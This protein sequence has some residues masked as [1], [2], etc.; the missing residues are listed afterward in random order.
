MSP[1]AT[2]PGLSCLRCGHVWPRRGLRK[3]KQCPKCGNGYWD[4][5]IQ[6][7]TIS[8]AQKSRV[9]APKQQQCE[10]C[11]RPLGAFNKR[12]KTDLLLCDECG[13]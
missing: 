11:K 10:W 2:F 9:R 4:K 6:Y 3:P 7:P 13:G 12:R 5:P 1:N 8:V